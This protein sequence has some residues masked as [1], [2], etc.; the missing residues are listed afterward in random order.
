MF[1][2]EDQTLAKSTH[3]TSEEKPLHTMEKMAQEIIDEQPLSWLE[4]PDDFSTSSNKRIHSDDG[5]IINLDDTSLLTSRT[6]D[7]LTTK[8]TSE[9]EINKAAT[10]TT[11]T[12]ES[13]EVLETSA[14]G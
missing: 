6:T 4:L 5:E 7:F 10:W 9:Y 8:K 1:S 11:A 12:M 13:T 14:P 2:E 3:W